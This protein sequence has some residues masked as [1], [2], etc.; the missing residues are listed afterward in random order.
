MR[1]AISIRSCRRSDRRVAPMTGWPRNTVRLS[2]MRRRS[3]SDTGR[4][5][6]RVRFTVRSAQDE[7]RS[8]PD[9]SLETTPKIPGHRSGRAVPDDPSIDLADA[10][11]LGRRATEERLVSGINVIAVQHG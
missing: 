4:A 3:G 10:D 6:G 2:A 1:S 5:G 9:E 11:D 7:E 8:A